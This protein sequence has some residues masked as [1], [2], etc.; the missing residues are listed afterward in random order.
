MGVNHLASSGSLNSDLEFVPS[1]LKVKKNGMELC[2]VIVKELWLDDSLA[3]IGD[4]GGGE[5]M[6]ITSFNIHSGNPANYKE[7]RKPFC[8]TF[9]QSQKQVLKHNAV[10]K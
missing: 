3:R 9:E 1:F 5:E 7:K 10:K 4:I 6:F 2:K 8:K